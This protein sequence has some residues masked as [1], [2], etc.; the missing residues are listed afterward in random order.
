MYSNGA[1]QLRLIEVFT[2]ILLFSLHMHINLLSCIELRSSPSPLGCFDREDDDDLSVKVNSKLNMLLR[3]LPKPWSLREIA[4]MWDSCAQAVFSELA[5]QNGGG[6]IIS[7]FGTWENC[8][9]A[10]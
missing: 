6:N 1:D 8:L 10:A 2:L 9:S 4:R 3:S 7:N 5:Q